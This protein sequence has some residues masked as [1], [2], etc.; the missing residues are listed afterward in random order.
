MSKF[1]IL[2]PYVPFLDSHGHITREWY[3][4]LVNLF[5]SNGSGNNVISQDQ[6][7]AAMLSAT[8]PPLPNGLENT[9]RDLANVINNQRSERAAIEMLSR[10]VAEL[11]AYIQ[12]QHPAVNDPRIPDL[13]TITY[14]SRPWL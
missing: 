5:Q 10:R 11:D 1:Q 9:L 3:A 14:G 8:R 6:F 4:F 7:E 12:S 2:A 13:Q